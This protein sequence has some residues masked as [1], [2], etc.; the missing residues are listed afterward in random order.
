M[1]A[2]FG[3]L[4]YSLGPPFLSLDRVGMGREQNRGAAYPEQAN[5][6]TDT[7]LGL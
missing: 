3:A 7:A 5:A 6:R 4:Q 2:P 1:M